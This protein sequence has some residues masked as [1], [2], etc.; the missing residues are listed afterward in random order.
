MSSFE[1]FYGGR[2]GA[3]FVIVKR[4][5]GLDIP[6]K[7][8]YRVGWFAKDEDDFFYVPLIER[9]V[10]NYANY[11]GW[12]S[13]PKDGAT[14]VVSQSGVTSTPLAVEYAEGM[15]QCFEKGGITLSEVGYGEYVMIDTMFGIGE[16]T[17]PDNGK[18]YRRGMNYDGD[19][20]GAE[21]IGQVVG[22]SGHSPKLGMTTVKDVLTRT[23]SQVRTY[24][25]TEGNAQDGIVPGKYTSTSGTTAF[26]DDID[27]AWATV[28]D[29]HG[30]ITGALI[31]F[32]FPYLVP[33]ITSIKRSPY[34]TEEDLALG[35]ITDASLIGTP[36]RD[37]DNF[38]LFVDNG[39]NTSDREPTHGDTGHPF[40]RRWKLTVPQG[41]KGDAQTQLEIVPTK[42]R[43]EANLWGSTDL[44]QEPVG[45]ADNTT[46]VIL[47]GAKFEHD[48][49]YPYN[50][51]SVVVAARKAS[52]PG[53][54]YYAK[55]D[56][57]YML[58]FRY[59]QT[60]YDDHEDGSD[61]EIIKL[62]DY[63]TVR[64]IWLA[65]DGYLWVSYNAD[66]DSAINENQPIQ[67]YE[68]VDVLENG[69][70]VF[71]YNTF[72]SD[73]T[74]HKQQTF[75]KAIDWVESVA[76][77]SI[78]N[79]TVFDPEGNNVNA[80][81]FRVIFN[82]DSVEN[83]TGTWTDSNGVA[84][85]VWETDITWPKV[86]NLS[87]D[88][89][90]K[91]LYNNNLYY[92]QSI[93]T[94]VEKGEYATIIPWLTDTIIKQNGEIVITFNNNVNGF[95]QV[96]SGD[97]FSR[98][99][100]YYTKN[101]IGQ[102]SYDSTVTE[103][104]FV[105]KVANGLYEPK[106]GW[107]VDTNTYTHHI[108]FIDHVT[109]DTDGT[110]HF[111]YSDGQEAPNSGYTNIKIKY[112]TD[113][114]VRTG[115]KENSQYDFEGEGSGDQRIQITYN[116]E[117][118]PGTKDTSVIGAPLNYIMEAIVTTYDEAAP[119]TPQ[120]HLLVLYSDPAY[121]HWLRDKYYSA[122]SKKNKIWSYTSQKF[123]QE[124]PAKPY[125]EVTPTGTENPNTEGWYELIPYN[126]TYVLTSDTTVNSTKTYYIHNVVYELRE[127]WFDLGYVKGEPGGLHII[128][129]YTLNEGETYQDYLVDGVP[130]ENMAGNTSEERGWAYLIIKPAAGTSAEERSIYTYD[131]VHEKW[132]VITNIAAAVAEPTQVI[133]MDTSKVDAISG[134]IIPQNPDYSTSPMENGLWLVE[135]QIKALY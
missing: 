105:D 1:S 75:N 121:R 104:N 124:D 77:A 109:I 115:V 36:I 44:T 86:A 22:P 82:N 66:E 18:V 46:Y 21:Y 90:L 68:S 20:G 5:D 127:D 125:S 123:T 24:D 64:K 133:I 45:I 43:P 97:S 98:E 51:S 128:G 54:T 9:T 111:W 80:G 33:E 96:S 59:R 83:Q 61:Y 120:N 58:Q 73:G 88:G 28:R 27:Y 13:I 132:V 42:I 114:K 92:D 87:A 79:P 2:Q 26:N 78:D 60:W 49:V 8:V 65:D 91:F 99:K 70:I 41:I 34:Y 113:V 48:C 23:E 62:G 39:M 47:D 32:T 56:D 84:H 10:D 134:K 119:N 76:L 85:A 6:D 107:N 102:Y 37:A 12:G 93:Y 100:K 16:N 30:N 19:L 67:W 38:V 81:H 11:P 31:G 129:S 69:T 3:S 135:T 74:T 15:K 25:M 40:Y 101:N 29:D 110:I 130:P 71:T 35:R 50:D 95:V 117:T 89:V 103:S 94:D 122:D 7:T 116:T 53:A 55:I 52:Q 106:S 108:K 118:I 4:F 112:L 57:T 126:N 14:T 17:N 131:Y 72:E 63:N